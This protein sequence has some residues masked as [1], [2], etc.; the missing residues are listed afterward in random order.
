V[1]AWAQD[2][3]DAQQSARL[4]AQEEVQRLLEQ[5]LR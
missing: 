3:L 4:E 1:C 2:L 5:Q